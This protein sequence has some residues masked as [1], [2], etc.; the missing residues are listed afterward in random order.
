M[1][2]TIFF[3]LTA[4][5]QVSARTN[6]QTVTYTGKSVPLSTVFSAI[7]KQTGYFFFYR[8][9]DLSGTAPVTLELHNTPLL[10]ALEQA[11]SGQP[12]NFEIQGSTVFITL[13]TASSPASPIQAEPPPSGVHG[14]IIDSLGNP[15]AGASVLVKG[16]KRGV[17]TDARGDFELKDVPEDVTLV[18]SFTGYTP[19]EYKVKDRNMFFV[20]LTRSSDPLDEA[21]VI[22]YGTNTRRF[23]VGSVATVTAEDIEKQPVT[24]VLLALEGRVPGLVVTPSSG[25]P[26]ALAQVQ[27][28]GQNT[29]IS[30]MGGNSFGTSLNALTTNQTAIP[31]DQPLFIIDGVPSAAGNQNIGIVNSLGGWN[32][33]VPNGG[34]SAFNGINPADIESITVL[35]DA[36]ATSI[37]GSQG[38]NGV[39]VITTKKGKPGKTCIDLKV[40]TGT[41]KVTRTVP[42]MNTQQYLQMRE[43]ALAADGLTIAT[44]QPTSIPDL[45]VFDTTRYTNWF[46]RLFGGTSNN[47]DAHASLSGGTTNSTFLLSGGYTRSSY[48]FPGDFSDDRVT[49]HSGYHYNSQDHRLTLDFGTDYSYDKNTSP[50]AP[51]TGQ[52]LLLPPNLPNLL[53]P[54]GN[55]IWSY[56]GA[57]LSSEQVYSYTKQPSSI[58]AYGLNGSLRIGYQLARGL[59]ITANVGYNR[60]N[61]KQQQEFPLSSEPSTTTSTTVNFANSDYQTVNIEP[62][63]DYKRNIGRGAFSALL[64]GTYKINTSTSTT[65]QGSGYANDAFLNSI[66][67]ATTVSAYDAYNIYKYAG[68]FG[69]LGYIYDREFIVSLTGR[70]DGSSN[71]GPGRQFGNFGSA[72]LGWIFSEER[73]FQQLLP[74]F[75]YAKISGNYGTTGSDG[76]M[77]YQFQDYWKLAP[78]TTPLFQGTR[79]YI[80]VNLY[81]PNYG[82]STKRALN[83]GL[84][85]GLFHDRLLTNV[86]WYRNRTGNELTNYFL[87]SQSGFNTVVENLNATLQ[88]AGL[89][90]T[91][92]STNI[93]TKK[94][95]WSTTFNISANRNKLLSFPGLATSSYATTYSIGKSTSQL[96]GFKYAGVN[97]TTGVFQF[98]TGKGG[99]TSTPSTTAVT[100]GGDL[101]PIADLQPRY[102]GGL[103]NTFTYAGFSLTAFFHFTKQTGHNYLYGIYSSVV[104]GGE[105]NLPSQLVN[106]FWKAPGDNAR[107]E[108]LTTGAVY[109]GLGTQAQRA[110]SYFNTSTG[111]ISDASYIRLQTLALS[112]SLPASV[113]EKDRGP[114]CKR[115]YQRTESPYDHQL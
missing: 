113:P 108:R 23:S 105:Y 2:L 76:V 89:E 42:M 52:A 97:D 70:R 59:N 83:V 110:A 58:Q 68:A 35:K 27:V 101:Q 29:L 98:Y 11:L 55:L 61:T 91:V 22:A 95:Q 43:Q 107:M 37:Y 21:Q 57:D 1:K 80:P 38:A 40:I 41:N 86:T 62:Q 78:S 36:D 93:K 63:I 28:R 17:M 66:D 73:A 18:V 33:I 67:A 5:L 77:P 20:K 82:W 65:L 103:G 69:R 25:A 72:G 9:E 74:V 106:Q 54:Q 94:F 56:K 19:R 44:A 96:F 16:S 92:T 45:L 79:G 53:D 112:Y 104:P 85:M 6:A 26:G 84:D 115:V 30:N 102:G 71:F 34:F 10:A 7:K 50:T 109:G 87:P 51:S 49:L 12:L 14:R 47:T 8:D 100:K 24:N 39:I 99:L 48:N 90:I 114:E 32:S 46:H 60:T 81:N 64:G 111:A 15:L 4:I 13:K 31:Y 75:S 3:L 88:D